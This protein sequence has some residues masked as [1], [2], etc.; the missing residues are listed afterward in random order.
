MYLIVGSGLSGAVIARQLALQNIPSHVIDKR[1]HIGGNCYDY[2]EPTSNILINKYGAHIFHT[3]HE[4]VW[5]FVNLYSEW[6]RYDHR[7]LGN[8]NNQLFPIPVNLNTINTLFNLSLT[9]QE[10]AQNW[11]SNEIIHFDSISNSE[12]SCLSRFGP[13]LYQAIFKDYTKKQW[14]KYPDQL[15]KS[16]CE[17]IPIRYNFDDRYFTDK[18]QALPKLGYTHFI[19]NILNHPNIHISLNTDFFSLSPET[20]QTYDKIIY[21]GPIDAYFS[22]LGLPKLEYRSIEFIQEIIDT[23]GYYQPVSVVNYPSLEQDF[24]RIVEYKHFLNQ[25]SDKTIIVREYTT[26]DGDPYYPV[27]NKENQD[28]YQEYKKEADK[29]TQSGKVYF[30]GRLANYKYFNMDQAIKNSLDFVKTIV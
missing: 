10:E 8:I 3:N 21:T 13:R 5:E 2:I 12:E 14:D 25:K 18:Y 16:V 19:Q 22:N 17:R 23:P 26:S 1:D 27:P 30:V 24:T 28:L 29:L 15:D 4:D 7:V 20:L 6:V 9:S 11:L